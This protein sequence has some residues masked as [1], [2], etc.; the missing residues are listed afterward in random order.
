MLFQ[1]RNLFFRIAVVRF[2]DEGQKFIAS[3]LDKIRRLRTLIDE[4]GL[5]TVIEIDGGWKA[6][7]AAAVAALSA[8]LAGASPTTSSVP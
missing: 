5:K 3:S 1:R 6:R 4:Q 2:R 7:S 8:A